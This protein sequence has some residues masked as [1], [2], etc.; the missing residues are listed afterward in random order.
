MRIKRWKTKDGKLIR[1]CDLEDEHL[2]N[3]LSMITILGA[4]DGGTACTEDYLRAEAE[5]RGLIEP[6]ILEWSIDADY[7]DWW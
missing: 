5:D 2:M 6:E 3:I 1:V 4:C 7:P